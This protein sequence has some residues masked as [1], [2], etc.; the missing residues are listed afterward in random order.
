MNDDKK[1]YIQAVTRKLEKRGLTDE[2][3]EVEVNKIMGGNKDSGLTIKT[4]LRSDGRMAMT[5]TKTW[6]DTCDSKGVRH[7]KDCPKYK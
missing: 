6:C 2:E 7:K 3:I 4:D 5:V 1:S